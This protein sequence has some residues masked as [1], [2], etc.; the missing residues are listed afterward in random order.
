MKVSQNRYLQGFSLVVICLAVVRCVVFD[1]KGASSNEPIR[2]ECTDV[3]A[4]S[5]IEITD[6][7][8]INRNADVVAVGDFEELVSPNSNSKK[9]VDAQFSPDTSLPHEDIAPGFQSRFFNA[10]GTIAK[11]RIRSVA[12]YFAAFPDTNALQLIYAKRY[13]VTPVQNRAEAETR[14]SELVYVGSNAYFY[15]DRLY[16]SIPYLVPRASLLLQ[17]IGHAFYDSLQLKGI[18]LHQIIVT[19]VLRSEDDVSRLRR[20]NTNA[21]EN[22]CHRFGTTFDISYNR[23]KTVEAPD[24]PRRREIRNDSLKFVL[25]EVLNDMRQSDRCLVKY[26]RK[27]GCFHITVK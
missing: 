12:N 18:P 26:E 11:H 5:D 27:Q 14:K 3:K 22:S 15:V 17:D 21:T 20:H 13:G 25:S 23:Y 2:H 24:G 10:D 16:S 1:G 19:S 9:S 8:L 4:D 6:S 7:T